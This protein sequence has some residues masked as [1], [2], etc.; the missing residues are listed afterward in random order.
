VGSCTR[1]QRIAVVGYGYWGSKH[2]RVLSTLPGV[3]VTVVDPEPARLAEAAARYPAAGLASDLCTALGEVDAVV[4]ATP[5]GTHAALAC[6][7]LDAG[8]HVLVE[9]PLTTSVRDAELLVDTAARRGVQLMVGHTFEYNAAVWK[10]RELVRSGALGRILYVDTARLSLGRYQTDVNVIWDLAPHDISIVSYVLDELPTSTQ[11]WSHT[12]IDSQR[13]DV[14]YLRLH[15]EASAV[16][17]YVHVSWLSPNKVRR[18]T[19]VGEKK[20]AVYD[21]M[22]DTERIRVYDV[23]VDIHSID[24]PAAAH[25]MPVSYRT[26]D[27]VSPYVPFNEPLMVQDQH[28]VD[29]IRTGAP[30]N[31]TGERGLAV[32]RVLAATDSAAASRPAAGVSATASL[33]RVGAPPNGVERRMT[34]DRRRAARRSIAS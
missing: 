6:Q 27:I 8:R 25:A 33:A 1:A 4:I 28:F 16:N 13:A 14:A 5:P 21:D 26:G 15:F 12:S 9:K 23:G 24:D 3:S 2:V 19:V 11:V 31:T 32:V 30:P 10:L 7:A 29:C 22:S 34:P 18:V 20:M 17:A